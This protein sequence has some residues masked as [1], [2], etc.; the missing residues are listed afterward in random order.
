MDW[1]LVDLSE[2]EWICFPEQ[3]YDTTDAY[4]ELEN[5]RIAEDRPEEQ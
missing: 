4:D 1:V 5:L 3:V 2:P